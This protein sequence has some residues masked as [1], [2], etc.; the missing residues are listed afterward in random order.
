MLAFESVCVSIFG[1]DD[2]S[3]F[4]GLTATQVNLAVV[5]ND[6]SRDGSPSWPI[7]TQNE[8]DHCKDFVEELYHCV[9]CAKPSPKN[10]LIMS[11][12]SLKLKKNP[13]FYT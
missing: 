12:A 10:L 3:V 13:V 6:A 7:K 11:H 2:D 8:S 9:C 4:E 5:S 1:F